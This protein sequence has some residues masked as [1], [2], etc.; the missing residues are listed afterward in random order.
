M[1]GRSRITTRPSGLDPKSATSYVYR[2]L[3]WW[4][5]QRI[6]QRAIDDYRKAIR[7]DPKCVVGAYNNRGD[8]TA[9]REE[10]DKAIEDYDRAIRLDPKNSYSN[11]ITAVVVF[12]TRRDEAVEGAGKRRST[13]M[14]G[15][16]SDRST[17]S[18]SAISA[19]S[20]RAGRR[21]QTRTFLDQAA[22]PVRY[23]GAWPYPIVKYLH[24]E[25]D[26]PELLAA[27]G[28]RQR[29]DDRGTMLSGTRRTGGERP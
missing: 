12:M 23:F 29:Q 18:C 14:A 20:R 3:G 11:I 8:A 9:Q 28:H 25:I 22:G 6:R 1:T 24:G 13:S 15:G 5:K 10:F 16:Q 2:G 21:R 19:R 26:R 17:P 4:H 27:A 7:L